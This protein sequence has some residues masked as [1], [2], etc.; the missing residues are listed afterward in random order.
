MVTRVVLDLVDAVG[1]LPTGAT[2]TV[3]VADGDA[4]TVAAWCTRTGN[5]LV[6]LVDGQ[7]VVRRGRASASDLPTERRPGARLWLYTN[8]DC[9]LACDYCCARSSPRTPRRALGLDRIRQL[10]DEAAAAGVTEVYLTGGEPFLLTDLDH[11]ANA[12]TARL[13]TTML[14]NGI[15]FRGS[16]LAM[17]R[18]MPRQRLTLQISL[19]SATPEPHDHHRG[20]GSWQRALDGIRTAL[21][22]GFHV[23]VAAT[24]PADQ[25]GEA[26]QAAF[27][28]LLD[29]LGIPRDDQI[30][31]PIALRGVAD[32]GVVL[33]TETLL[34][35]VTVTAEGVYWHPVGA[36]HDDQ[37]VTRDLFPLATA[38]TEIQHRFAG[39]RRRTETGAQRFPCA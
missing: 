9:N 20:P 12:C 15:L 26:E 34:P 30:V 35:E 24:V 27:H 21:A 17:L 31:R 16:R 32:T 8:F 33:T 7:A 3:P 37:L 19:D 2:A 10:V 1:R 13:P 14:T 22:E 4:V 36:D 25:T 18:R 39:Y 11:I 28:A 38:I 23:R 29:D 6:S 5:E